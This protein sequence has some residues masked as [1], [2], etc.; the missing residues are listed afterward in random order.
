MRRCVSIRTT[1]NPDKLPG[2]QRVYRCRNTATRGVRVH[3]EN[4]HPRVGT[5]W[6]TVELCE[7]CF[8]VSDS[9]AIVEGHW[10]WIRS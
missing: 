9:T 5:G 7:N 4:E 2:E 6:Y 3:Q 1:T 10:R 8:F